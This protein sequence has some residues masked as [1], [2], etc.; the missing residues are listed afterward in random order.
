MY[1]RPAPRKSVSTATRGWGWCAIR[2]V[3]ASPGNPIITP[4]T[5]EGAKRAQSD[6]RNPV[7]DAA[8]IAP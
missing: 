2:P 8:R 6:D 1:D 5:R 4:G 7:V 3:Q